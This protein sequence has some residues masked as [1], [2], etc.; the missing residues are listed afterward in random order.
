MGDYFWKKFNSE[1]KRYWKTIA[2]RIQD[3]KVNGFW[4]FAISLSK[5][6]KVFNAREFNIFV[7]DVIEDFTGIKYMLH[8]IGFCINNVKK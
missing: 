2:K 7:E 8:I 6:V 1:D 4:C 3:F 5:I